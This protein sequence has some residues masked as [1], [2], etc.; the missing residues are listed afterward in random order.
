M[1]DLKIGEGEKKGEELEGIFEFTGDD[2]LKFCVKLVGKEN[3]PSNCARGWT[4]K[5]S[6]R[7]SN[8]N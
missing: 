7:P 6:M 5:R 2:E 3:V 1:I 4:N 8:S